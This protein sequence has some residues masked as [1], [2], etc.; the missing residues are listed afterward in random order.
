MH[1]DDAVEHSVF[2]FALC[3]ANNESSSTQK[4]H[5][6]RCVIDVPLGCL[7]EFQDLI[8]ENGIVIAVYS[9]SPLAIEIRWYVGTKPVMR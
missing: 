3:E 2:S 4:I 1:W 8:R 5:I 9:T 7:G 6:P